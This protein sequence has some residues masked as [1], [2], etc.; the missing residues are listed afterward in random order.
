MFRTLHIKGFYGFLNPMVNK[1][2]L[3][4]IKMDRA[5][6][7]FPVKKPYTMEKMG[8]AVKAELENTS[9]WPDRMVLDRILQKICATLQDRRLTGD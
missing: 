3:V 5:S 8:L 1:D 7:F 6:L 9:L 4:R 2:L